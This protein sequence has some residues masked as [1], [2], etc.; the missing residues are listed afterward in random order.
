MTDLDEFM[1]LACDGIWDCMKNQEVIDYIRHALT[2]KKSLKTICEEIMDFCLAESGDM[3]GIGCDNMT[4][5]IVAFLRK[6]T[7]AQ[8]YEWMAAKEVANPP[9][10]RTPKLPPNVLKARQQQQQEEPL[11]K[12]MGVNSPPISAYPSDP[13]HQTL[14]K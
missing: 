6:K 2:L 10:R 1:V 5:I 3:T 12:N 8:W 11:S 4:I 14:T 7:V 9:K 13:T